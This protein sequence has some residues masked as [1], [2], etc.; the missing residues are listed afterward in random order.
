MAFEM[1]K[2]ALLQ[3]NIRIISLLYGLVFACEN[4][5]VTFVISPLIVMAFPLDEEDFRIT[6]HLLCFFLLIVASVPMVKIYLKDLREL[7]LIK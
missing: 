5:F 4:I 2:E 1:G 3:D 7:R 6:G